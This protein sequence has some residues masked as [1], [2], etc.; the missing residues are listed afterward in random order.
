MHDRRCCVH[1]WTRR[2]CWLISGQVKGPIEFKSGPSAG[3]APTR[4]AEVDIVSIVKPITSLSLLW[5][6]HRHELEKAVYGIRC[7][8]VG[9]DRYSAGCSGLA[10]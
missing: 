7:D 10:H 6:H 9:L 8:L 2:R 5:V 3:I 4:R 1:G